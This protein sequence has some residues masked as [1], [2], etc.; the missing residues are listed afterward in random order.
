MKHLNLPFAPEEPPSVYPTRKRLIHTTEPRH[1]MSDT[2]KK[3]KSCYPSKSETKNMLQ[4]NWLAYK[5]I[6]KY[7]A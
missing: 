2:K 1:C 7:M 3:A 6:K 4:S 5:L